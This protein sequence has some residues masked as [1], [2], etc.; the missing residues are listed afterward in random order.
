MKKT[1]SKLS[2]S[3]KQIINNIIKIQTE[4]PK[5]KRVRTKPK[6]KIKPREVYTSDD[7]SRY[8][9][10]VPNYSG[11]ARTAGLLQYQSLNESRIEDIIERYNRLGNRPRLTDIS[12][13]NQLGNSTPLLTND[14]TEQFNQ[15]SN[16]LRLI[17]DSQSEQQQQITQG[18]NIVQN[19]TRQQQPPPQRKANIELP[20]TRVKIGSSKVECPECGKQVTKANIARHR[21]THENELGNQQPINESD[22]QMGNPEPLISKEAIENRTMGLEDMRG[23]TQRNNEEFNKSKTSLRQKFKKRE[24]DFIYDSDDDDEIEDV[25]KSSSESFEL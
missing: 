3:Q 19:L 11:L 5:K 22:N 1:K 23:K 14:N 12:N 16:R 13:N 9:P 6:P 24:P 17:E 4:K 2:Q 25:K 18:F 21:R 8:P 15:L 7:V 10:S 20:K